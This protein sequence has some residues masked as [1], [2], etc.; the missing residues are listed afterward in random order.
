MLSLD[1]VDISGELQRDITHNIVKT[2]LTENGTPVPGS[3]TAELRND[4]DK[5]N[6]QR[7]SGYCGS[8][9]GGEPPESGCCNSCDAVRES[10]VRR[11]WSFGNPSSIDQV[12]TF[13]PTS[14][15]DTERAHSASRNTG[16]ST[17]RNRRRRA[18]TSPASYES[19]KS[20]GTSTSHRDD[21]SKQPSPS[22]TT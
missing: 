19:T 5:L 6:E 17:Y 22:S 7:S 2:R 12:R 14:C 4:I 13:S 15:A 16:P 20:S 18:V 8:C 11:G 1:V 10:Y 21:P 3:H 9:Y